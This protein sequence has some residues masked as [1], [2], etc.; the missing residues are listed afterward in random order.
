MKADSG[1]FKLVVKK[2][3]N[4]VG[5][6]AEGPPDADGAVDIAVVFR[7]TITSDEWIQVSPRY[8]GLHGPA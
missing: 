3:R 1:A 4:Y 7:G 8:F 6:V 2:G 5:F